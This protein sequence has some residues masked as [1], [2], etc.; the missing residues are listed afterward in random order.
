MTSPLSHPHPSLPCSVNLPVSTVYLCDRVLETG[1]CKILRE[2]C[3]IMYPRVKQN[4]TP[5]GL[6][7]DCH[8]FESCANC[9]RTVPYEAFVILHMVCGFYRHS[10]YNKELWFY[11]QQELGIHKHW[12][13]PDRKYILYTKNQKQ[14]SNSLELLVNHESSKVFS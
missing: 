9:K 4:D 3:Y 1:W 6:L 14:V 10:T 13:S 11:F 8:C 12:F 2:K 7:V 5:Q